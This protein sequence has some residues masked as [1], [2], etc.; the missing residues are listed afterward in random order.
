MVHSNSLAAYKQINL[1]KAQE[2][3]MRAILAN[4]IAGKHSTNSTLTEY[5]IMPNEASPRTGELLKMA[6]D[7]NAFLLDGEEY[8]LVV[9]GQQVNPRSKRVADILQ[10]VPFAVVRAEWLRKQAERAAAYGEQSTLFV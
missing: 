7:G 4:T 9:I 1:T 5:N 3:V 2:R 10:V 8:A 6:E